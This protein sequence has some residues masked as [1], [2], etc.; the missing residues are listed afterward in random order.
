MLAVIGGTGLNQIKDLIIESEET[1]DTP[2]GAMSAPITICKYREKN[3]AFL[4]RH[5]K[6]HAIPP[7]FINY[8]ANLWGLQHLAVKDIISIATVGSIKDNVLAGMT[9]IPDQIIDYTYDREH[10][11]FDGSDG[12]VK[13]I[14]F[15]F[16]FD[17]RLR[18]NLMEIINNMKVPFVN[19]AVYAAVQGPRLETAA[20]IDRFEK[21]GATIVG[22]TCMPEAALARELD[23]NYVALCPVANQAAG[24]GESSKGLS[25][26]NMTKN[27]EQ[28][29]E[30]VMS[31]IKE[32]V[33]KY[34]S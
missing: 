33:N 13:H 10:S 11:F 26:Q 2:Y 3:I 22:M 17:K 30:G 16:P 14:D 18:D 25:F 27:S 24:R 1:V 9:V 7:H 12:V 34:G 15:T 6:E 21:D 20:E 5:G 32:Y 8:R 19:K 23:I 31:I 29:I 4:P 28:M